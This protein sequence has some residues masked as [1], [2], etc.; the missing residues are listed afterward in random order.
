M[1]TGDS[2]VISAA[3]LMKMILFTLGNTVRN[4]KC[5]PFSASILMTFD[6]RI[7]EPSSCRFVP[8]RLLLP[9]WSSDSLRCGNLLHGGIVCPATMFFWNFPHFSRLYIEIELRIQYVTVEEYRHIWQM[10]F[11][12]KW[13][14]PPNYVT[15]TKPYFPAPIWRRFTHWVVW[16]KKCSF[17]Q[18]L[19]IL[20]QTN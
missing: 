14:I 20:R 4:F 7:K 13:G 16:G 5:W 12:T 11:F 10:D 1:S 8:C 9:G 17:T 19:N 15:R 3:L 18:A 6:W 2:F